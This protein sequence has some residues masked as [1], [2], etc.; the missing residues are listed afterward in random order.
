MRSL[1]LGH[2]DKLHA[3]GRIL[4]GLLFLQHGLQL[5]FGIFG[6]AA[7]L[8]SLG[9]FAGVI[10]LIGGSLIIVGLFTR[11]AA[12]FSAVEM[13]IAYFYVHFP[14]GWIPLQNN[15]ELALVYFVL[16]FFLILYGSGAWSLER[17]LFDREYF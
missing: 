16:F 15:G 8:F 13:L 1:L 9:W 2:Q 3:A 17:F 6:T 10:E 12:F 5:L 14:Q 4:A 11:P 7:S